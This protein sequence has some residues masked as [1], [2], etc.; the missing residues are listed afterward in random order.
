[1]CSSLTRLRNEYREYKINTCPLQGEK[2]DSANY[3]FIQEFLSFFLFF[4]LLGPN[5]R[6]MEV[7]RL[8]VKSQLWPLAYATAIATPDPSCVF[9]LHHSSDQCWILNP[10]SKSRDQ[11][12]LL[13][14]TSQVCHHCATTGNPHPRIFRNIK[15]VEISQ[16][17]SQQEQFN[18]F[19][20]TGP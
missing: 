14:D 16:N 11:I 12:C 1:M 10:L 15:E 6:H 9:D 7:P 4:V 2:V 3:A 18:F 5:P 19:F 13:M 8:G 17:K 20:L